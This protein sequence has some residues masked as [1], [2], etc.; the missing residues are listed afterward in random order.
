MKHNSDRLS[1]I[2]IK[3]V[4]D[5]QGRRQDW[6]ANQVGVSPA[7]VNRWMKGTRTVD[8]ERARRI[9]VILGVPFYL[10]W[11]IPEG[12][13]SAPNRANEEVAA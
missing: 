7:T 12:T 11:N 8:I 6:L 1:G 9:A 5:Q 13:N 2:T 10:L 4:L 3:T